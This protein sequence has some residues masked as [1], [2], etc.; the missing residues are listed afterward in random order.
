MALNKRSL[1]DRRRS[2]REGRRAEWFAAQFF[3]LK[4]YRVLDRNVQTPFGEIDMVLR[5]D[6]TVIFA[7]IKMR[8][9]DVQAG[10]AVAW[11]QQQRISRA[12]QHLAGL[13]RYG[14][15]GDGIRIDLVLLRPAHWPKHVPDA[16]RP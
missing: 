2:W 13:R 12:V 7:E 3:R 6:K 1:K 5:R 10:A 9:S 15:P 14:D 16:W 8:G 4:G 11:K